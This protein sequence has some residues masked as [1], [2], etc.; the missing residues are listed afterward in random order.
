[1]LL[2]L[3]PPLL[4]A[5]A[6]QTSLVDFNA[7]RR[8]ILLLSVGLVVFTTL[9]VGVDRARGASRAS[10]GRSRSRSALWSPRRTPSRPPPSAR[11]IG[12][13]RRI[14][15][16]LEG[17]SLL[18]DATALVALRTA[19]ARGVGRRRGVA[20][21]RR[22]LIASV[23][24]ARGRLRGLR[25]GRQAA[26][27]DHRSGARHRDL[28]RRALRAPTSPPRRSRRPESIAVV[29][30]GLLLG[31]KAP[32]V[33]T[34]QSRIAERMNWRTIAFVLENTVFLLIGLQAGW[35][36]EDVSESTLSDRPRRRG[37][38]C[39]T[40]A[41]ASCCGSSGCS[42][43]RYLLVRPGADPAPAG[44][45]RGRSRCILGWAGMRGVVTLAAAF[46]DPRQ[47]PSTARCCC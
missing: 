28:V 25:G 16:I 23:G 47:R 15:T 12:L 43:P 40:L 38:R 33:Q 36:L 22:F 3:L 45:R 7:N 24:G 1:M 4:Y 10:R 39:R 18:N 8:A 17:E 13:P 31:H 11:R 34:A 2:G 35:I 46:V 41:A 6:I 21:R 20:R 30:A 19:L 26:Q 5:A 44:S 27:A 14:V 9:G 32:V 37:L 29:V 42:S